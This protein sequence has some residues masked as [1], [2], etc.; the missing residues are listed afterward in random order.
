MRLQLLATLAAAVVL[1]GC[2][3]S[4]THENKSGMSDW[5]AASE[6]SS[7]TG[8]ATPGSAED[9]KA[10]VQDRVYFN[11]NKHSLAPDAKAVA[12]GQAEWLKKWPS[13]NAVV[14]GHCD[15]RGTTEYNLALGEKRA[16]ALRKELV[17]NGVDMKRLDTVSYGKE[18]PD[19]ADN[20]ETAWAKNRRAVV[21]VR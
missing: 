3:S 5:P 7:M 2:E 21:V 15:Q 6:S 16:H 12:A 13:V 17:A 11:L 18:H 1:T 14:E 8:T 9:F 4:N 10:T 19:D 20:T